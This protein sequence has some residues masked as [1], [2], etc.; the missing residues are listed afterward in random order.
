MW[1][2]IG[3]K[4]AFITGLA[5]DGPPLRAGMHNTTPEGLLRCTMLST[6]TWN[7]VAKERIISDRVLKS[8]RTMDNPE[9]SKG[10]TKE[11]YGADWFG[12][13]PVC[14]TAQWDH[15]FSDR[16]MGQGIYVD[17]A[18]EFCGMYVG[19]AP[20]QH[21]ISGVGRSPGCLRHAAKRLSGQSL[22]RWL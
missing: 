12:R 11:Q 21:E 3:A 7:E 2:K 9:A 13:T 14:T 4:N 20:N 10:S 8:I 17:P 15:G 5:Q 16:A 6:P 19:L 22:Q 18:R 1:S